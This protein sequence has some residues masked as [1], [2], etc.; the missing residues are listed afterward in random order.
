M[1]DAPRQLALPFPAR[2]Q[3][4]TELLAAR[5]R[6]LLG[7]R[8]VSLALTD[9]C[10]TFLAVRPVALG[11][12]LRLHR[13][14]SDAPYEVLAQVAA[15][16]DAPRH[17]RGKEALAALR[18][19]FASLDVERGLRR[20]PVGSRHRAGGHHDL[21]LIRDDVNERYFAGRLRV[22][23]SWSKRPRRRRR[24]GRRRTLQLGSYCWDDN[25]IRIHP[26]LD[27]PEVPRLV[28]AAVV[29]HEMV[30]AAIPPRLLGGRR[31][32][33]TTEFRQRE[34]E[35]EGLEEAD[36]WLDARLPALLRRR[37][38]GAPD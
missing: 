23:I 32:V 38:R 10:S 4:E 9:N 34:R 26:V 13:G 17:E 21:A 15:F 6:P 8:L 5:L 25:L 2:E 14:F 19:F 1:S 18:S 37:D 31:Y 16:C 11:I 22:G 33:H 27:H 28:V 36:R 3:D 24:R 12:A 35:F 7:R 30:H 20:R 29:H